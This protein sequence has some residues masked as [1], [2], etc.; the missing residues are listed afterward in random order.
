MVPAGNKAKRLSSVNHTI[1]SIHHHIN[2]RLKSF[3][4][5]SNV[6]NDV[7]MKLH[8]LKLDLY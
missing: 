7:V 5:S 6:K 8:V 2:F 3:F 1:K 4:V